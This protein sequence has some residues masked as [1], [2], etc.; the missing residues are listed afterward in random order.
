MKGSPASFNISDAIMN[1][2]LEKLFAKTA[3]ICT[4]AL[5]S[6]FSCCDFPAML[7]DS[8]L[9]SFKVAGLLLSGQTGIVSQ[10][11]S[12]FFENDCTG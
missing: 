12:I 6:L 11:V 2:A 10:S 8:F 9:S 1:C 4:V 7:F 5:C 3:A